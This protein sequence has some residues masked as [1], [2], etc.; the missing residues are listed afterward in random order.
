M[1]NEKKPKKKLKPI[2]LEKMDSLKIEVDLVR[3]ACAAILAR[4]IEKTNKKIEIYS[5]SIILLKK[6]IDHVELWLVLLVIW[7]LLIVLCL[8]IIKFEWIK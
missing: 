3:K 8:M 1:E 6:R 4:E 2:V 5:E 7:N